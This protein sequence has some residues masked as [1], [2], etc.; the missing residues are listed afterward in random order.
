MG[1]K[2]N[3]TLCQNCRIGKYFQVKI[4]EIIHIFQH[5]KQKVKMFLQFLVLRVTKFQK[6]DNTP[7]G[8]HYL[9]V[10]ECQKKSQIY[11]ST[12]CPSWVI[13]ISTFKVQLEFGR[14]LDVFI[15]IV[16]LLFFEKNSRMLAGKI[17]PRN[18]KILFFYYL[19]F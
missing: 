7:F 2:K 14:A 6:D 12:Q 3:L 18:Q 16:N 10:N 13:Y 9:G 11:V 19:L 4:F 1:D 15:P 17:E 5:P 8:S